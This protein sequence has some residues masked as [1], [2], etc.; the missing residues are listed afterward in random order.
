MTEI[1][2][3]ALET[4]VLHAARTP[5]ASC[6]GFL[7]GNFE[8]ENISIVKSIPL[9]HTVVSSPML[10]LAV[11][12]VNKLD[13]GLEIVGLY[14]CPDRDNYAG[15]SSIGVKCSKL[16]KSYLQSSRFVFA[17]MR[18]TDLADNS[19]FPLQFFEA[20]NYNKLIENYK[21]NPSIKDINDAINQKLR[22]KVQKK[23]QD[24][25]DFLNDPSVDFTSNSV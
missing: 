19:K 4:I 6:M 23:V 2:G 8:N 12:V 5:W 21:T 7:C 24:F 25:D 9:F 17:Q 16:V 15:V 18:A 10:E 3:Q 14:Y 13:D 20:P 11:K 22:K 1:K